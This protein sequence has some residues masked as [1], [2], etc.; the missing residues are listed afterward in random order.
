MVIK[1]QEL[2]DE[3]IITPSETE[4]PH[5]AIK[6]KTIEYVYLKLFVDEEGDVLD[7]ILYTH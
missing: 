7:G 4:I 6:N 1:L 5:N 3:I 2:A